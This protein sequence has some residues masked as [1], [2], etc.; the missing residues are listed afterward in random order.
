MVLTMISRSEILKGKNCPPELEE[1]LTELLVKINK[2][3]DGFGRSMTVTSG[4][5][6]KADQ[7]RIYKAKGITDESKIPMSSKHFFCQAV[8]ISDPNQELQKW[9]KEN[10]SLVEKIGL[11][12]EDFKTTT[13]WVHAQIVPPKSG[14]RFFKP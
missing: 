3:R 11:W 2:V 10:I 6:D 12:F 4:L 9:I 7:L 13:N 8:D 14:N 5:R 1:N